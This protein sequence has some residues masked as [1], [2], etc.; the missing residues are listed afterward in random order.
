MRI[1]VLAQSWYPENSVQQRRWTWL[2]ET[3]VQAGHQV[4][5][6]VP[7]PHYPTG[8]LQDGWEPDTKEVGPSG[9]RILRSRFLPHSASLLTRAAD[10]AV[11]SL[12]AITKSLNTFLIQ[13]NVRPDVIIGTVPE[14]PIASITRLLARMLNV[15]YI[16]DLR[17]AWPD[18]LH[19]SD[20]WNES[21]GDESTSSRLVSPAK[22]GIGKVITK[23]TSW[24]ILES[25]RHADGIMVT[26]D[27]FREHLLHEVDY[28]SLTANRLCTVRNVF[29][30]A[31][32]TIT[33]SSASP[34]GALNV[35]YAGTVGRAQD[36]KSALLAAHLVKASGRPIRF[37]F[38]G[39]G[40]AKKSLQNLAIEHNIEAEFFPRIKAGEM[41]E[42]YQWADTALV[43]LA[44]WEPMKWTVPSKLYELM[45]LGI[46]VSGGINGEAAR[47]VRETGAGHVSNAQN[48]PA[49]AKVWKTLI[50]DPRRL[51]IDSAPSEW[52][53]RERSEVA[54]AAIL[55]LVE[56]V[57][58]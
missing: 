36:L 37:R 41:D 57:A 29:P 30:Q 23:V 54:P 7:P 35:V 24:Q 15:P 3:L 8:T 4:T 43:N 33:S 21:V 6:V 32:P 11:V 26:A 44:S 22:H 28:V 46:H 50:E 52:V 42:H 18:L 17:D 53:D 2:T 9:E 14:L 49:L 27:S 55:S 45:S 48:P 31:V 10:Q 16:I 20:R 13:K 12:S 47:L 58:R 19:Y 1:L 25:L 51:E 5:A 40:A 39:G 34:E 56:T 38:I